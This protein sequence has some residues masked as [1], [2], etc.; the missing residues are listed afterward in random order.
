[1]SYGENA[2]VP[3]PIS[4]DVVDRLRWLAASDP[5]Q[6]RMA[7]HD[8][9]QADEALLNQVLTLASRPGD[10]RLRQMIATV[11]RTDANAISLEP[12]LRR[13]IEVE[14]DEFT[15]AAIASALATRIPEAAPNRSAGSQAS[16]TLDAYRY[17]ADR[18]CHRVRNALTLPNAQIVRLEQ[19]A[20]DTVDPALKSELMEAVEDSAGVLDTPSVLSRAITRYDAQPCEQHTLHSTLPLGIFGPTQ[21]RQPAPPAALTFNAL[22]IQHGV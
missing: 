5:K 21:S 20:G 13:W 10:G 18:L 11:F 22:W 16:H 15:K 19:L 8:L 6:A 3:E 1:M 12:W 4:D 7:F 2:M 9:L 14:P 17:V